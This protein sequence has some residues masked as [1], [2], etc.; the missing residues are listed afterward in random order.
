[1]ESNECPICN[2]PVLIK[3]VPY[4]YHNQIYFGDFEAEVCQQ[5]NT[6]FFTE[7]SFQ[8]IEQI[9]KDRGLWGLWSRNMLNPVEKITES[10]SCDK[11]HI[12][13]AGQIFYHAFSEIKKI[14]NTVSVS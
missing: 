8:K 7:D 3:K 4:S 1:M 6:V 2:G 11:I 14:I 12:V 10:I 13:N 5:C 9:A